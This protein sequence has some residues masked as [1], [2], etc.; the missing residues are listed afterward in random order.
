MSGFCMGCSGDERG[1]CSNLN[2]IKKILNHV[3]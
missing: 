1:V 2:A 3:D